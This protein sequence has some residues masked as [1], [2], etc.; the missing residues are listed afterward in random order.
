MQIQEVN[1]QKL[2]KEFIQTAIPLYKDYPNWIRPLDQDI[3]AI[4]NPKQNKYFRNGE[5]TRWILKDNNG[6]SST[7]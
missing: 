4:F 3:E 2:A 7:L 5:C 6:K 1:N